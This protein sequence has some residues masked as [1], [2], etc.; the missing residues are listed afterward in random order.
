MGRRMRT[1]VD[2]YPPLNP[3]GDPTE[4]AHAFVKLASYP[5][6]TDEDSLPDDH[7][8]LLASNTAL[9][10]DDGEPIVGVDVERGPSES[11]PVPSNADVDA[12]KSL[13]E[14]TKPQLV[15]LAE[16]SGIEVP[17][18]ISRDD[19]IDLLRSQGLDRAVA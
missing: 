5:A 16:N 14:L 1:Y 18:R 10:A 15:R 12:P 6:G 4:Q 3:K 17:A 2:V 19:L 13:D 7:R 9:W 11:V 8:A